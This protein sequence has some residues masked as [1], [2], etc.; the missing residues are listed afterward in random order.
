MKKGYLSEYFDG[1][2]FKKLSAVEADFA[3]SNQHEFNGVSQL[4]GIFGLSRRTFN[5][6]FIYVCDNDDEPV[7]D[8]G[9][10]TWYDARENHPKRSEYRMYFPTTR[11]SMC[12]S[13]GDSLFIC[14]KSNS[15]VLVIVAEENSTIESQLRWLFG[16]ENSDFPGFSVREEL[17]T[18]QDRIAYISTLI[19]ESI[20]V[21]VEVS[22]SSYL[23][24]MI[25]RFGSKF[26][27]TKEFSDYARSTLG[28]LSSSIDSADALLLAY[29]E[30]E[31]ILFR[32]F[33]KHLMASKLQ[34]GFSDDV[35]GFIAY[36]LAIQNRRKSRVGHAFENHISS[37]FEN[38]HIIYDHSKITENNSKP[39]F[40]FPSISA[41]RNLS[42]DANRLTI[43]GAKTTCKDRWRQVLAEANRV[44]NK[45]L[46]TLEPS[47]SENQTKEMMNSRL[48]LVVPKPLHITFTSDQRRWLLTFDDF[49]DQVREKQN[50]LHMSNSSG[51]H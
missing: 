1:V 11:V 27:T 29:M 38:Q 24:D 26:P 23:D 39:D 4:K 22:E 49:I 42:F 51:S 10:L 44:Q 17:E 13:T 2:A 14:L 21:E 31:E 12:G 16:I 48:Q 45:H 20:G 6:D 50:G 15:T 46:I 25:R 41:Y 35:D 47:I 19:L 28:E 33:E 18:Y 7:F 37:I 40:I 3:K 30:R 43:L 9:F 32:T 8:R 34:L 5:A 36:S